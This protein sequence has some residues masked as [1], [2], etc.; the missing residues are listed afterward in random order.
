MRLP[1]HEL[2]APLLQGLR[3]VKTGLANCSVPIE[4]V[5]L[6]NL[7]VSQI[8]GCSYCLNLHSKA[9]RELGQSERRLH[10]LAGW[11]VSSQFE[12]RERAVLAW[13]EALTH[14]DRGHA[15]DA[16]YLPLQEHFSPQQISDLSFAI[17]LMNAFNRLAIGI[18]Q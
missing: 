9:L 17:A 1:Y 2:S 8:N 4:L 15:A 16:D 5:E 12:P 6:I 13:A 18:R 3:Q 7:R 10:E 14:I 11:R